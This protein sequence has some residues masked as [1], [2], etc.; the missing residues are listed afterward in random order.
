MVAVERLAE[1]PTTSEAFKVLDILFDGPAPAL[2]I[3]QASKVLE[4]FAARL[5]AHAGEA[6]ES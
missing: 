3:A 1:N 6:T 5:Q 2:T 4:Y